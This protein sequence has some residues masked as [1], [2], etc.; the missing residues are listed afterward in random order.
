MLREVIKRTERKSS[1][2]LIAPSTRTTNAS[3]PA[4]SRP[5]PSLLLLE[6][7]DWRISVMVTPM[8]AILEVLG[9]TSK[10]RT[11]PPNE[12][13]SATPGMVRSSGRIT[14]S[15]TRRFSANPKPSPS[16]V[17][18]YTSLSGVVIG[19]KPPLTLAGKSRMTE[20]NRSETCWRAQYK[21]T[22]SS[23]SIVISAMP[24]LE[25]ERTMRL[26]GMLSSSCS[27]GL[28][29]RCSTSSGVIPGILRITLACVGEISGN[30]SI[31]R[32]SHACVPAINSKPA[33][34]SVRLRKRRLRRIRCS[35]ITRPSAA[36]LA[37]MRYL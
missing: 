17:N 30:A 36:R 15:R 13:T 5:A 28:T 32:L 1:S 2:V 25:M 26:F 23:K 19:A 12:L 20:L 11:S 21:S 29:T 3:S 16:S 8:A 31:G 10:V 4:V 33:Q 34:A 9:I 14:Q 35:N 6:I 27:M 7:K 18:M 22:P 37:K 24:Y